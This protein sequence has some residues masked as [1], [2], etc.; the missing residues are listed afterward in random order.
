[1]KKQL[2]LY[3]LAFVLTV[4][5]VSVWAYQNSKPVPNDGRL[6]LYYRDGCPHCINVEKFMAD[7]GVQ[8]KITKLEVKE[9]AINRANADEMLK[10]AAKCQVPLSSVGYPFL[11]TG[12]ECL[13][14]DSD[15]INYFSEQIKGKL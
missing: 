4:G 15:V 13:M 7:N 2:F 9:G 14:G 6:I 3:I 1:M 8:Q 11:W 5:V 12:S 10:F